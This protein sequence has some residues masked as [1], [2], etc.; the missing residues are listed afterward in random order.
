MKQVIVILGYS[1]AGYGLLGCCGVS[2]K[3]ADNA[4]QPQ[5]LDA[6]LPQPVDAITIAPKPRLDPPIWMTAEEV[7]TFCQTKLKAARD[8]REAIVAVSEG[9]TEQ[10]TL[11]HYSIELSDAPTLDKKYNATVIH[12]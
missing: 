12:L 7:D 10:N 11:E 1:L 6:S 9:R 5:I 3:P 4:P 2:P 8:V